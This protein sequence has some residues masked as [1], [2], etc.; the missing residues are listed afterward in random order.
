MT[1]ARYDDEFPMNRKVGKLVAQGVAG[2]AAIGLHLLANTYA[3]HNGTSGRIE[4]HVPQLLCGSQG[5]KLARLLTEAGMFDP[6]P[7]GGWTIH[8]YAEFHDPNDP[9]PNRS[10]AERK[11]VLSEKRADAGRL[12]GLAKAGK[13]SSNATD[14]PETGECEANVKSLYPQ[15]SGKH[16]ENG[17]GNPHAA[18]T[19]GKHVAMPQQTS[20]PV[21]V[22]ITSSIDGP[23]LPTDRLPGGQGK[24]IED[25]CNTYATIAVEHAKANGIKV[26]SDESYHLKAVM[27]AR[28]HDDLTRYANEWPDAPPSAIAAWLH[29][30]KH[31]MAYYDR[32]EL[33]P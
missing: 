14:L 24:R 12:G 25:I 9:E 30:D 29:G 21:P 18:E 13:R 20:S 27:T 15:G 17:H 1:W 32:R 22:P 7:S 28:S 11:R 4:D 31:S 10:A 5:R 26:R 16:L 2:V 6:H 19:A 3:R 33:A 23:P 8:D